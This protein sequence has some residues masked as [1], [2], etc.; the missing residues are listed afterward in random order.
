MSDKVEIQDIYPL[1]PMQEGMLY[2]TL[3]NRVTDE[4]IV[5]FDLE[6][7]GHVDKDKV[8]QSIQYIVDKYDVLRAV[9]TYKKADRP[10]QII[11]KKK[12]V[13]IGYYDISEYDNSYK[14]EYIN[15]FKQD[16]RLKGF[17]LLKGQIMRAS[18]IKMDDNSYILI[19]SFHHIILDGWS[20]GVITEDFFRYYKDIGRSDTNVIEKSVPYRN[21]ISWVTSQDKNEASSYWNEYLNNYKSIVHI[22]SFSN[23]NK[24]GKYTR[25]EFIFRLSESLTN[26]LKN[27]A[28]SNHVTL[29]TV[30]Q[31]IWAII[32]YKCNNLNDIVFGSV[33]S[34]RPPEI[35]D[36]ESMVGLFINTIPV[37]IKSEKSMK[38]DE[39]IRKVQNSAILSNKYSYYPLY[40]IQAQTSLKNE[41]INHIIIFEN[42]PV[43]YF[44][45][46]NL[47][48]G[49]C[50]KDVNLYEQISY[51]FNIFVE[52]NKELQVRIVYN[53]EVFNNDDVIGIENYFNELGAKVIENPS[54]D[55]DQISILDLVDN[56]CNKNFKRM[57]VCS[58]FTAEPIKEYIEWWCKLFNIDANIEFAPYNQVFQ[59]L[60]DEDSLI[61]TNNGFNILLIR[62]ED[63]IRDDNSP[64]TIKC[65][66][67]EKEYRNILQILKN[68]GMKVPYFVCVFPT[69]NHLSLSD[70]LINFIERMNSRW[71]KDLEDV[72]NVYIINF[73]E[74]IDIYS[75]SN[76]FDSLRD[77]MG[78]IPFTDEFYAAMGTYISRKIISLIN[79]SFKVIVLDCD[80]TMWKG[81]CGE[82]GALGVR[83]EDPFKELQ[84]FML[85]RC[86]EGVLLAICSKN[87]ESDVWEVF[88]KNPDMLLKKEHFSAYRINWNSKADNI[89]EIANEL[90]LDLNSFIFID[91]SF[92]ECNEMMHRHPQILTLKL[93]DK[94]EQFGRFLKNV[95]AFDKLDVV[96]EDRIRTKMY[97]TERKRQELKSKIPSMQDFLNELKI[98]VYMNYIEETQLK[99]VSQLTF[100]T[101]QFNLSTI[102]RTQDEL[103]NLFTH[104]NIKA[105]TITVSD[106]F[107][108]YGLVGVI[109]A[110]VEYELLKIDTWLLSC[111]VLGRNVEN[112]V[113]LGLKHYCYENNINKVIAKY[114]PTQKNKQV[115]DY[116]EKSKWKKVSES[117]EYTEYQIDVSEI[118]ENIEYIELSLNSTINMHVLD[119][120]K[121]IESQ[122]IPIRQLDN[123]DLDQSNIINATYS[124]SDGD[125]INLLETPEW[126]V[127]IENENSLKYKNY[128]FAVSI[129]SP[130][131]LMELPV[132]NIIDIDSRSSQYLAPED[133]LEKEIAGVWEKVLNVG[134][135][136]VNTDFFEVGGHSL[137]AI[138]LE[139]E[140][141]KCGY[142][143]D[144]FNISKYSTIRKM[145]EY[146]KNI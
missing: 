95:W 46:E 87:N 31:T 24:D 134:N 25:K 30:F 10:L 69:S 15:K 89:I 136:G 55:I 38:F 94:C 120:E 53:E 49:I 90:N 102:R 71:I 65:E 7:A 5:Q 92:I 122:D 124:K 18:L 118:D 21:Y 8:E 63:W 123:S 13:K 107:G 12:K 110:E 121:Y 11:L 96:D 41:L 86:N 77:R 32:L 137:I 20:V 26:G 117:K 88:E 57:V 101:N 98:S 45:E 16:D 140:L 139:V 132:H 143:F 93:P 83:I 29:N 22:P 72:E 138:K 52:V 68:K 70:E 127:F 3:S 119:E 144:D 105:W 128:L 116:L 1:T 103:K 33:V 129:N 111:R 19:W 113:L 130:K 62:F 50:V 75:I 67:L 115:K 43:N 80:N 60:I 14:I 100:R 82:D 85:D 114:V 59:Q 23:E 91:D 44:L 35:A 74:V 73:K 42:F 47:G 66:K 99:R 97:I 17:D 61:S 81:I 4:Y 135:I 78:H 104:P 9:F 54:V 27:V 51:D 133:D 34:D 126:E 142:E 39:L 112:A 84:K 145:A 64:D 6:L 76:I 109:I 48:E 131:K 108:H 106:G 146:V 40:E 125:N 58:T 79:Q 2:H 36:I 28:Q 37:R 141:E 56:K